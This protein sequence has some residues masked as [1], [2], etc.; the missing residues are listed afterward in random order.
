MNLS[1]VLAVI[2]A[3]IFVMLGAAKIFAVPPMRDLAA[4]AGFST[5]AYR[6]IGALEVAGATGVALGLVVP[7]LGYMAGAGLL[8][9]LAGALITHARNRDGVRELVPAM[10]CALLVVGYLAALWA[11]T[12]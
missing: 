9:L 12:P 1:L 7:L 8:V 5:A 2:V 3:V 11:E 6:R 10:V 4:K